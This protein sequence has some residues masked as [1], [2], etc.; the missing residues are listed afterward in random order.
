M[1]VLQDKKDYIK[2]FINTNNSVLYVYNTKSNVINMIYSNKFSAQKL[3]VIKIDKDKETYKEENLKNILKEDN[4]FIETVEV[5]ASTNQEAG[6]FSKYNKDTDITTNYLNIYL[7]S[8]KFLQAK[9]H[10][11]Y[12][13]D[14]DNS[15]IS[16]L[17]KETP[18][19]YMLLKNLFYNENDI[20]LINFLN[21]LNVVAFKNERQDIIWLFK[22]TNE[23]EQGQ[24][25]G[26]GVLRD[27]FAYM[28]N[29]LIASV[30][31]ETYNDKFNSEL[32]NKKIVFFDELNL[33]TLKY[34]KLKDITGNT[35]LRIENK[36]KDAIVVENVGS[37]LLFTNEY[38]LHNKIK[39]DDRRTFIITPNPKNGSLKKLIQQ[40][41]TDFKSFENKAKSE[42][43]NFIHII[44]L[45]PGK[46]KTP[47]ELQTQAHRAYFNVQK[48]LVDIN[49]I[50]DIFYK[51]DKKN[52]FIDFLKD[53]QLQGE[54]DKDRYNNIKYFL[55]HNFYY[56]SVFSVVFNV[57][58]TYKIAG[59]KQND[60]E[61]ATIKIIKDNLLNNG[62]ELYNLDTSFSLFG[63]KHKIRHKGCIR[64]NKDKKHQQN[65][66]NKLKQMT[67]DSIVNAKK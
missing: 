3:K 43:D 45:T 15:L 19:L 40:N 30:S 65:I 24:G 41:Y 29:G 25:A 44:A 27:L 32:L 53:L 21:W 63:Q 54:I 36:G 37:W 35:L 49:S 61:Q 14:K 6:F 9:N 48:T 56:H 66:N 8:T 10:N 50:T 38:D 46:V 31:N 13:I 55:E 47:L 62:Y 11:K 57:C 4:D 26:K 20:V 67:I 59:I 64:L 2:Y 18:A 28:F 42:L 1:Y 22:G 33:K 23:E 12:K 5:I 7:N 17:K 52:I 60:T 16:L 39:S 34:D 51:T 58:K